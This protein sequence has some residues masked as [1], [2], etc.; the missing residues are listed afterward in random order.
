MPDAIEALDAGLLVI[1]AG[2]AGMTAAARAARGGVRALVVERGAGIGGSA[3]LSGGGLWTAADYDTFRRV[4]PLGDPEQ[5]RTLID[6]YLEVGAWIESLGTLISDLAPAD[7]LMG[8]PSR[9]RN[10]DVPDYIRRCRSEVQGAG[11]HVVTE[12]DTEALLVTDGRVRGARIRDL[13]SGT[14]MEVHAPW[15]LLATGG[16]QGDPALRAQYLGPHGGA[17]LLRANPNSAGAG[18]RL[19]QAAGAATSEH[20]TGWYGHTVPCPLA[21]P[22]QVADYLRFAQFHLSP[23]AIL[24][25]RDG[26]RFVDESRGYY[27]NAQA[28]AR[29]E[30]ARALVLFDSALREADTAA[31]GVDRFEVAGAAGA[32]TARAG[33]WG[34]IGAI[35]AAWGYRGAG[36]AAETFNAQMRGAAQALQPGRELHR[37]PHDRAPFH[38][39]EVQPA[40]TFT[41]GGLRIDAQA[42]VLD[43]NGRPIPGLLAAGADAGG[44]YHE[45]YAGG[46]AMA[47][48][49]GLQAAATVLADPGA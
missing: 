3:V 35:V 30:T 20:M 42:R 31:F 47:G 18:L 15:T 41:H 17:L 12:S 21:Q 8:F 29:L 32:H 40:I 34:E 9:G 5:A 22:M 49:F 2:M 16:F 46:L 27:R 43:G 1:G 7:E 6:R 13:A 36:E 24:L 26:R 33:T 28:V 10:F 4:N 23:R 11:G 25:D 39:I 19:G 37:R 48:G 14:L 44:T 45:A 38:A